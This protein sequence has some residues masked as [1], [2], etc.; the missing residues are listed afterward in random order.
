MSGLQKSATYEQIKAYVMEKFGLKVSSL[1]ISQAERKCRLNM[2]QKY[3]RSKKE[4]A[5]VPQCL[6][7]KE[8]AIMNALKYFQMMTTGNNREKL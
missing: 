6:L 7:K 4:D 1:Y 8:V 3:D 5:T 2:G